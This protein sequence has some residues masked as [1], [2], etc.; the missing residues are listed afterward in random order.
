MN[1]NRLRSKIVDIIQPFLEDGSTI[2]V[3]SY[4]RVVVQALLRAHEDKKRFNVYITEARPFGLG[5]K[6]HAILSAAGVSCSV[7]LDSAVAY[8]L[9]KVDYVL[10]G[11]E[12]VCESG[13]LINFIGS[14][15]LSVLAKASHTPVYA[16]AESYKFTRLL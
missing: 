3:H 4:S 7:I 8:I 15:G 1:E 10:V 6:T 2:L 5:L 16:L 11:S 9:G 14:Y 13:A 12:A